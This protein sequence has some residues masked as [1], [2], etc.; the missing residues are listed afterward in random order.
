M[1]F[2]PPRF[3]TRSIHDGVESEG[4]SYCKPKSINELEILDKKIF[5]IKISYPKDTRLLY[6]NTDL[7]NQTEFF[8][9]MILHQQ[10]N[11]VCL[12]V[13]VSSSSPHL[14]KKIREFFKT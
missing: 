2:A 1:I 12:S 4:Y 13:N 10:A 6:L 5:D 7:F 9:A 14:I 8:N 11:E 3:S